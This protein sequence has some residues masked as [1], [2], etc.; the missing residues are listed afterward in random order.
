MIPNA[1]FGALFPALAALSS[2]AQAL[3]RLF[4]RVL[5]GLG[6]YGAMIG[7]GTLLVSP[8]LISLTY[9]P[10]FADSGT[11]L[12]L[13]AWTLLP[14]LLK[15]GRILYCYAQ[16]RERFVNQVIALSLIVQLGLS[17]WLISQYGAAGAALAL[18]LTETIALVLLWR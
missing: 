2:D 7:L 18:I 9:G 4:R 13:L 12:P 8:L 11:I 6:G 10:D 16:G 17:L 15:S 5:L 14:G 3:N 1:L